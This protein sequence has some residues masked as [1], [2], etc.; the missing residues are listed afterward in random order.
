[1]MFDILECT[2]KTFSRELHIGLT[3]RYRQTEV[4][5]ATKAE[6]IYGYVV[7][8]FLAIYVQAR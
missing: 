2:K 6:M 3:V 1:M 4:D 7:R 8:R 5:G